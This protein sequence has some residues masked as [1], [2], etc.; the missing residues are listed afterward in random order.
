MNKDYK[1]KETYVYDFTDDW[2]REHNKTFITNKYKE[3][4][5]GNV[6]EFGSNS[7]YHCYIIAENPNVATVTAIDI[8]KEALNF[9]DTINRKKFDNSISDKVLFHESSLLN[10]DK[11]SDSFDVIISFHTIEHIY[12]VDIDKAIQEMYRTLSRGGHVVVSLP[13]MRNLNDPNH[14]C[15]YDLDKLEDLFIRNKFNKLDLYIDKRL[16]KDRHCITG[17]FKK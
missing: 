2:N 17:I 7:G 12:E 11:P 14:V 9:G 4:I 3:H 16:G 10:I 5:Y 13:Y 6:A 8:N 1:D 15:Y